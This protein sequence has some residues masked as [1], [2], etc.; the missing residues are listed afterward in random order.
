MKNTRR[1]Y[2]GGFKMSAVAGLRAGK[3]PAQIARKHRI[4]P[5]PLSWWRDELA[6]NLER[7]FN[8]NGNR[9][10]YEATIAKP[11]EVVRGSSCLK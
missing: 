3:P 7:A 6:E 8:L 2:D 10:K 5:S 9:C 11:R 4:H 1:R